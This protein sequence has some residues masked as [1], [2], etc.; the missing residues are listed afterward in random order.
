MK[1]LLRAYALSNARLILQQ[2][3]AL[4]E[5]MPTKYARPYIMHVSRMMPIDR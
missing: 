1:A 3:E 2:R 5:T 4:L